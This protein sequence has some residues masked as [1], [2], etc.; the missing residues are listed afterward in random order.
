MSAQ[1]RPLRVGMIGAG[2]IARAHLPAWLRLGASVSHFSDVGAIELAAQH[3]GAAFATADELLAQVDVVDVATPTPTHLRYI[4]AAAAAGRHAFCEKPLARTS[5]EVRTAI[6]TCRAAGVQLYPG[7]VVRYFPEYQSMREQVTAGSIGTI[8]V[9]RFTRTGARPDVDWFHDE[10]ASGGIILDQ[11][12]HDL[13]FACWNAGPALTAFA[14]QARNGT[15]KDGVVCAQVILTHPG[16]AISYVG[17]TWARPGT[18]FR[19]TFEVA[20]SGGILRHDSA[21]HEPLRIDTGA[22]RNGVG[23][24]LPA[25]VGAS[26]FEA[27][28]EEIACAFQGGQPPRVTAEDGLAAVLVAEAA[29]ESLRT[30]TP[31]A[32][33]A[34][35]MAGATG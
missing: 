30:G 13:D 4:Q 32:V 1:V 7:H 18:R 5:R 9:Q 29:T 20:G 19:T 28:L 24:L 21:E 35:E 25:F 8:A 15:G 10:A 26:P 22:T 14:R 2:T 11:M 27:E 3:G 16:G 23:G 17:C 6:E 34:L 33:E 31:V 12:I